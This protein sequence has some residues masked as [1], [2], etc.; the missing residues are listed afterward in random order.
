MTNHW[1]LF[2][3]LSPNCSI[4]FD[5]VKVS[6]TDIREVLGILLKHYAVTTRSIKQ[7]E[8]HLPA[9]QIYTVR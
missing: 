2:F 6:G 9:H 8:L 1:R 3:V 5:M 7:V 4:V